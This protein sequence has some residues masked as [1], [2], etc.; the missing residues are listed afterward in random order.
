MKPTRLIHPPGQEDPHWAC[1]A[2]WTGKC[3]QEHQSQFAAGA[4]TIEPGP[5]PD[6]SEHLTPER[7]AEAEIGWAREKLHERNAAWVS[8]KSGIESIIEIG[9]GTGLVG[10]ILCDRGLDWLGVDKNP[11]CL[12]LAA[13]RVRGDRLFRADVREVEPHGFLGGDEDSEGFDAVCSFAFLKHFAWREW[14]QVF[15]RILAMANYHAY[16]DVLFASGS[17]PVDTG[18]EFPH[19]WVPVADFLEIARKAGW[20]LQNMQI[21]SAC[22]TGAEALVHLE[23]E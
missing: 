13:G 11:N 12:A 20:G 16:F 1:A 10:Q 22:E 21:V 14:P 7:L 3:Q 2:R 15:R 5:L 17:D 6:Y 8:A 23:A 9:C 4:C 19:L 18:E